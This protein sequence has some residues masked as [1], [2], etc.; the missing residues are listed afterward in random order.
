MESV[1]D[2][3][4]GEIRAQLKRVSLEIE[5]RKE[6]DSRIVVYT[7]CF[8][9]Y[10]ESD[11]AA[12]RMP[13]VDYFY[14]CDGTT[15]APPGWYGIEVSFIHRDARR[16]AKI[17]KVLPHLFLSEYEISVW[18]DANR[19]LRR[20]ILTLVSESTNSHQIALFSH[21]KRSNI[22]EEAKECIKRGLDE[23][24]IIETQIGRYAKRENIE[25][26]GLYNGS[27]LIRRHSNNVIIAV[28][29]LWWEEIEHNSVRDQLSLPYVMSQFDLDPYL[30]SGDVND[31]VYFE[32]VCHV[33]SEVY[34]DKAEVKVRKLID[35]QFTRVLKWF[36]LAVSYLGFHR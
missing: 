7:A 26:L 13:G 3:L 10:D 32:T 27:F 5:K 29:N 34:S 8:N 33:K 6:A 20:D 4:R 16:T 14:I 35:N 18:I 17:F 28:M 36:R 31:N 12:I 11:V 24:E 19:L 25:S 15:K 30:L 23:R 2:G 1:Y 21:N 22:I 9:G